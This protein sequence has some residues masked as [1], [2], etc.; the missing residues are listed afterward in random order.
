MPQ[1]QSLCVL[2]DI[3]QVLRPPT[4][5][6]LGSNKYSTSR[7]L[8]SHWTVFIFWLT[9]KYCDETAFIGIVN[10]DVPH[11]HTWPATKHRT[12]QLLLRCIHMICTTRREMELIEAE[13]RKRYIS[14]SNILTCQR[15][16]G[17]D[18]FQLIKLSQSAWEDGFRL[19]QVR[20]NI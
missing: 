7:L 2:I 18:L 20:R 17:Q 3:L 19:D 11:C 15:G 6:L 13:T 9:R 16:G 10:R 5:W 14:I 12:A 8:F 4:Y 1:R